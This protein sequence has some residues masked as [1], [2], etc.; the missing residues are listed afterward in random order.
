[1]R[2]SGPVVVS[3]RAL[4]LPLGAGPTPS[5]NRIKPDI[6]APGYVLSA[7]AG[8]ATERGTGPDHCKV[9]ADQ[10]T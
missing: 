10:V 1:M 5:D 6:V 2:L 3:T 7:A 4:L 9:V 8:A